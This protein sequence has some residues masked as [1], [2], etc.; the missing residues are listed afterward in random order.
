MTDLNQGI[1]KDVQRLIHKLAADDSIVQTWRGAP[2]GEI[3]DIT[4]PKK[5]I[6]GETIAMNWFEMFGFECENLGLVKKRG[7]GNVDLNIKVGRR[8]VGVEIKFATMDTGG[9][10]QFGWIPAHF[11]YDLIFFIGMRP[12]AIDGLILTAYDMQEFIDNPQPRRTL[13]AVPTKKNK[14]HYK[15]TVTP[16]NAGMVALE[17]YGDIKK[18][19][20][21]GVA[22]LINE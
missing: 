16:A 17:T 6:L 12:N 14:T 4:N 9:S 21:S 22:K 7:G 15:W 19:I 5:G 8:K 2:Y 13:T 11:N 1:Q 3:Q 20:D 10:Y 18:L